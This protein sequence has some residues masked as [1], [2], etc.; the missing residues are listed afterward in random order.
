MWE[1]SFV[2]PGI[3]TGHSGPF[4]LLIFCLIRLIVSVRVMLNSIRK[5]YCIGYFANCLD[6][7]YCFTYVLFVKKCVFLYFIGV[8]ITQWNDAAQN[9]GH[10]EIL[11]LRS[12]LYLIIS[13]LDYIVNCLQAWDSASTCGLIAK[14]QQLKCSGHN[15]R[16]K[17]MRRFRKTVDE[18]RAFQELH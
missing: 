6:N 15:W 7:T 4:L 16:N 10:T 13:N 17:A 3:S 14:N 9:G 18:K 8:C 11:A 1:L 5:K 12:Q 2:N